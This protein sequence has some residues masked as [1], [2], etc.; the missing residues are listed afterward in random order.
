MWDHNWVQMEMGQG[1]E[2]SPF[3]MELQEGL[4]RRW[5][6]HSLNSFLVLITKI[7]RSD[8][9]G[10]KLF[11]WGGN[12]AEWARPITRQE[13]KSQGLL[14]EKGLM[15]I[16]EHRAKNQAVYGADV[17]KEYDE[18]VASGDKDR[19]RALFKNPAGVKQWN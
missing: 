5:S 12:M 16:E 18:A 11:Q 6:V 14:S 15:K 8:G 17:Y 9:V 19:V 4:R 2:V 3:C 10:T 7:P 1:M 13:A